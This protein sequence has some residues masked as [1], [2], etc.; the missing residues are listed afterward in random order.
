MNSAAQLFLMPWLTLTR[1]GALLLVFLGSPAAWA[2]DLAVG[3][4]ASATNPLTRVIAAEYTQGIA[5]GLRHVNAEGGVQGRTV[6]L[7]TYDDNFEPARTLQGAQQLVDRD[8]VVALVGGLGTQTTMKLV[9][10]R[11][12]E[13]HQIANFAP[14]TGLN[15]ALSAPNVFPVRASFDD[16]VR[17]MLA[18]AANLQREKVAFIYLEAGAGP[19]LSR[20][21]EGWARAA[22]VRLVANVGF[23]SAADA[24]AQ[25]SAIGSA[26]ATL[27]S[28]RPD[29][30]ILI[31]VGAPY[32]AMVK[33]LRERL[34]GWMP[35][36]SL[37]QVNVEDLIQAVG[38]PTARN[39][40]LTQVMPSPRSVDL[41]IT[42]DFAEDRLRWAPQLPQTYIALEGYVAARVLCEVLRRARPLTREGVLAAALGVGDLSVAGFRVLYRP[43]VRRSLQPVDMTLLDR[44]A[45]LIR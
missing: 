41:R 26:L 32:A 34:G 35:I 5:L 42:R 37:G 17:A 15:Q 4:L 8:G 36:Y 6:K 45:R 43:L 9:D 21:V 23:R 40:S 25:S 11:F 18:H 22:R 33:A 1:F 30:A 44:E 10:D 13:R 7:V 2:E 39:V 27:G 38:A 29:A 3:Q 19:A 12:L 28:E 31:A 24:Q 20:Q 16:E 14:L